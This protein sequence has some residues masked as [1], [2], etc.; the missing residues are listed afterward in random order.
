VLLLHSLT[1]S[2]TSRPSSM[3]VG[4]SR[5]PLYCLSSPLIPVLWHLLQLNVATTTPLFYVVHFTATLCTKNIIHTITRISCTGSIRLSLVYRYSDTDT[6][7]WYIRLSA[8][9]ISLRPC[10]TVIKSACTLQCCNNMVDFQSILL[11]LFVRMPN[12][13]E[14]QLEQYELSCA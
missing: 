3:T 4:D 1:H 14:I 12:F 10:V 6:V 13:L 11:C 8:C 9:L 7:N 5:W 2:L